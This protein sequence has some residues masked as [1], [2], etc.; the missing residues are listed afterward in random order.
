MKTN[1]EI[2]FIDESRKILRT[3]IRKTITLIGSKLI[4]KFNDRPINTYSS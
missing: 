1:R 2:L 3:I 4:V